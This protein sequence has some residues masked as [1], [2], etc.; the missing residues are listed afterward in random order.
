L[1]RDPAPVAPW[2]FRH[3]SAATVA[4]TIPAGRGVVIGNRNSHIYHVPGCE[5]YSK[6]AERN[7]VYFRTE[8]EARAA[9]FR[10]AR[11]CGS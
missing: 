1:W 6:V 7:R 9:G 8:A 2:E 10:K 3:P 11:N 5:D 4:A